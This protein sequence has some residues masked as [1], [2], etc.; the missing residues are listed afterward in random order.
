MRFAA[1]FGSVMLVVCGAAT[2][3][4]A[5]QDSVILL[6]NI[7][8]DAREGSEVNRK[9][10]TAEAR[11]LGVGLAA[12]LPRQCNPPSLPNI[13]GLNNVP[14]DCWSTW[15]AHGYETSARRGPCRTTFQNDK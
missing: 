2:R 1:G 7:D 11:F 6:A 4:L 10:L 5:V 13:W 8:V 14:R 12:K 9:T 3:I 15:W